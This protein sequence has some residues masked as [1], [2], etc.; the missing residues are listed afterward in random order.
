MQK[1]VPIV[2]ECAQ[3]GGQWPKCLKVGKTI[4]CFGNEQRSAVRWQTGVR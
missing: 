3:L 2:G 1:P 4:E